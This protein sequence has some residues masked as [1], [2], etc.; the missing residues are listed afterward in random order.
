MMTL[1]NVRFRFHWRHIRRDFDKYYNFDMTLLLEQDQISL[2]LRNLIGTKTPSIGLRMTR[3][4]YTYTYWWAGL[5]WASLFSIHF[6]HRSIS[7]RAHHF[8]PRYTK[9]DVTTEV[10][11]YFSE[12][13]WPWNPLSESPKDPSG[14]EKS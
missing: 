12:L 11:M 10:S 6:G 1:Q 9:F 5:P 7:P 14:T 3:N 4:L 8:A 13:L 2:P